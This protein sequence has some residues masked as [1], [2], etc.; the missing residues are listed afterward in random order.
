MG[1]SALPSQ[2]GVNVGGGIVRH[3]IQVFQLLSTI[4][5]VEHATTLQY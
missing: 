5:F 4:L 1:L 3:P 2:I